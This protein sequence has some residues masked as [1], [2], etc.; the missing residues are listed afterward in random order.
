LSEKQN[1][2]LRLLKNKGFKEEDVTKFGGGRHR[3][4][5]DPGIQQEPMEIDARHF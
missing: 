2:F 3:H 5:Q 1:A 4:V